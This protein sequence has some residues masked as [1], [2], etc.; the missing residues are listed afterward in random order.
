LPFRA[1]F[2]ERNG[3]FWGLSSEDLALAGGGDWLCVLRVGLILSDFL[4]TVSPTYAQEILENGLG[5]DEILRSRAQDL[6]GIINGIDEDEWDPRCDPY[7][8]AHYWAD[9]LR[10]KALNRRLLLQG[11]GAFR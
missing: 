11:F 2:P 1:G 4:T 7:L 8:W 5:L 3:K 6:V 9:D 10:G